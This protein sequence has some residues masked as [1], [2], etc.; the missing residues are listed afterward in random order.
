[1][2]NGTVTRLCHIDLVA[3]WFIFGCAADPTVL[4]CYQ[5]VQAEVTSCTYQRSV[6]HAQTTLAHIPEHEWPHDLR[7]AAEC[8]LELRKRIDLSVNLQRAARHQ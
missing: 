6:H 5:I 8:L 4:E 7:N 2:R 3:L 1:M